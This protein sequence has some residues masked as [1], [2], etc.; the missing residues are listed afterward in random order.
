MAY[1]DK[2]NVDSNKIPLPVELK[3]RNP[4][5][6]EVHTIPLNPVHHKLPER[7]DLQVDKHIQLTE[8]HDGEENN[9]RS[10][11]QVLG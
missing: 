5:G 9:W 4:A 11:E 7:R 10:V 1:A 3:A 6:A 2:G 8:L